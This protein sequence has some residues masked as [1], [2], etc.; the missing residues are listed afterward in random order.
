LQTPWLHWPETMTTYLPEEK[1]LFSCDTFGA[2]RTL[3]NNLI[4]ETESASMEQHIKDSK[5]YFASVF[6]TEREW[7]LKALEKFKQLSIQIDLV[8]P[9]HGPA[10]SKANAQ[11][12]MKKWAF[13][14]GERY[15]KTVALVYGSMY[16]MT[17]NCVAALS[18]GVKEA[19]GTPLSYNLSECLYVD[20]LSAVVEAPALIIGSPTYEHEIFPKI[21]DFVNLLKTKKY[22]NRCVGVFGSFSWSGEATRTLATE[23]SALGFELVEQPLSVFGNSTKEDLE[24]ARQ[25]GKAVTEKAFAKYG[26]K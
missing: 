7:V 17:E 18:E 23:L 22:S 1:I 12:I 6:N 10:Y 16:G 4:V 11:E 19:G 24:K 13:W 5:K 20:A 15:T 25:L 9:S 8:A 14:S 21:Q 3:P 2:F 26:L